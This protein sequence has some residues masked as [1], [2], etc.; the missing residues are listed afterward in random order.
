MYLQHTGMFC[1]P[2]S[3]QGQCGYKPCLLVTNAQPV[4]GVVTMATCGAFLTSVLT[5]QAKIGTV[6]HECLKVTQSYIEDIY[7]PSETFCKQLQGE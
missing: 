6:R 4:D 1:R 7:L 2:E 5:A 3:G